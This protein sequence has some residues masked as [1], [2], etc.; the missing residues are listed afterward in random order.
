MLWRDASGCCPQAFPME[1][2]GLFDVDDVCEQ[3]ALRHRVS[4]IDYVTPLS[5]PTLL[6]YG[7]HDDLVFQENS[8][9]HHAR[10]REVG[11]PC[12]LLASVFGGHC[13]EPMAQGKVSTPNFEQVQDEL[14]AFAVQ[15]ES[16]K[17]I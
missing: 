11:A 15:F 5:V 13:F 1:G 3:A 14:V 17:I 12:T 2:M 9:R 7:T 4:P 16:S 8:L 6:V 10:C